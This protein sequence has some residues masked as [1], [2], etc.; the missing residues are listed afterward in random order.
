MD[1]IK[2]PCPTGGCEGDVHAAVAWNDELTD[3]TILEFEDVPVV[4]CSKRC[5]TP[6][7]LVYPIQAL[8]RPG[9]Q[10]AGSL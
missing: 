10:H 4:L 7:E 9:N 1:T 6:E 2:A 8:L 5:R 3:W